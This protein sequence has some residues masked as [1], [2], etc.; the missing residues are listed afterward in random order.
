VQQVILPF[1][2]ARFDI[3]GPKIWLPASQSL[4]LVMAMHELATNAA[5]YGALSTEEGRVLIA[6]RASENGKGPRIAMSWR[7]TGGP[8]A[9]PPTHKGF[10][11]M[12]LQRTLD[13]VVT[14]YGPSGFTCEWQIALSP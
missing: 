7:E 12:L 9:A 8:A 14:D 6:W 13:D 2:P 5:K 4:T 11:S 3:D 1:D 10:G